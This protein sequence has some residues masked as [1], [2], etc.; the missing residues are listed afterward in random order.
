M[1][2]SSIVLK[3]W[4]GNLLFS[5]LLELTYRCNLDCYFC[6]NDLALRGR[7]LSKQQYFDFFEGLRRLG[8]LNV[9]LSGG[10][11]LAHPDFFALGVRARELGFVTRVKSNGHALHGDVARRLKE[12]VDPFV[13]ELSLHGATAATHDR[14]TRVAGSFERLMRNIVEAQELGLR[15]K[16]NSTLTAWNEHELEDMIALCEGLGIPLQIDPEVSPK[17]DGDSEPLS[18]RASREAVLRL[19]RIQAERRLR[20]A[21]ESTAFSIEREG[22]DML[23]PASSTESSATTK[24]CGA[25]S[26]TIAVDPFGSVYPCVQWRRAVGNLHELSI[27]EIWS[28]SSDLEEIR[29]TTEEVKAMI[30]AQGPGGA[31]M[32]FCPGTAAAQTGSPLGLYP[33]A[34]ARKGLRE[35]VMAESAKALL[36]IVE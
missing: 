32:S 33:A 27:E 34:A 30:D 6:Y 28:G 14:Q 9:I 31:M 7:P 16:I 11:P 19:F 8:A 21:S 17:D 5:A 2:F 15:L 12:E 26:A 29:R 20:E 24:H 22:D 13:I 23:P 35:H 1:S 10:E 3:A 25:G 18:I 36:P 4:Q